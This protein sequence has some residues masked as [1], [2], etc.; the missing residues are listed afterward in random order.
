MKLASLLLLLLVAIASVYVLAPRPLAQGLIRTGRLVA[1]L[2][3]RHLR[4]DSLD[5]SYLEGGEGQALLMIHGFGADKDNWLRI[6]RSFTD[7]YRVIAPDLP[8]FGDSSSPKDMRFDVDSQVAHLVKFADALGLGPMHIVGNSMGGQVAAVLASRRPELVASLALFD[9]LGIEQEPG[10]KPSITM[11]RLENG[12]NVLLPP[13][14]AAFD[15]MLG[16]MF[17]EAPW[18]PG[19]VNDYYADI[20]IDRRELL[21]RIFSDITGRYVALAP[22]LPT[23]TAPTLILWG[24]NDEILPVG[25]A[26]L[27][28]QGIANSELVILPECGHLPMLEKPQATA[29]HYRAFL[30]ALPDS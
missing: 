8:G 17:Y 23:L 13:D 15:D 29:M 14:R 30:D 18:A 20:W 1:G 10:V 4:I 6:A 11:R 5:M 9:P 27:L 19:V 21:A 2:E 22:L 25:G 28:A 7:H 3:T 12:E 24:A 16:L 26:R